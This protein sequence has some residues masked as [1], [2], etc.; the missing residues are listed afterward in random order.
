MEP[1]NV[2]CPLPPNTHCTGFFDSTLLDHTPFLA[3]TLKPT[4]KSIISTLTYSSS[5]LFIFVLFDLGLVIFRSPS[6][7]PAKPVC[8]GC[9]SSCT[10]VCWHPLLG[11]SPWSSLFSPTV[12]VCPALSP[13]QVKTASAVIEMLQRE[14]PIYL[15]ISNNMWQDMV[16]K[17]LYFC[18]HKMPFINGSKYWKCRE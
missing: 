13:S 2:F 4:F 17:E 10:A 5:L 11:W 1:E 15:S 12:C 14:L 6:L 8:A 16:L 18:L 3:I 7:T 9:W